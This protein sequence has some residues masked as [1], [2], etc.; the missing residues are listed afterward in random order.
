MTE[1][2]RLGIAGRIAAK[3]LTT[4][5]TPLLALVGML[6]GL[7]RTARMCG[8]ALLSETEEEGRIRRIVDTFLRAYA[9]EGTA[10]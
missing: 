3:F 6:M 9:P 5:I 1:H 7:E 4:E 10:P 2:A 8:A